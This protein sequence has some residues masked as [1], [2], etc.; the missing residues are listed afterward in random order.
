MANF[1]KSAAIL[2][3]G[4]FSFVLLC[5]ASN[6]R[7]GP[8]QENAASQEEVSAETEDNSSEAVDKDGRIG[9]NFNRGHA[10]AFG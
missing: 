6:L 3:L 5:N 2:L 4:I 7:T 1:R 9:I 10:H 8:Q